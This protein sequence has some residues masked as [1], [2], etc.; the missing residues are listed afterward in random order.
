MI[1]RLADTGLKLEIENKKQAGGNKLAGLSFVITGVFSK[2]SREE[3]KELI[4]TNGGKNVSGVSA[5]T[6]YLLAG[7]DC[8]P[9][10]LEKADKLKIKIISEDEFLNMI[11]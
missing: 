2:H 4:E 3:L 5:K 6:N 7:D 10:K 8:G 9:S 11:Q 1:A